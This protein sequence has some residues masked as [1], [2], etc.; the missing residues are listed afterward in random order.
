MAYKLLITVLLLAF[1]SWTTACPRIFTR[2]EWGARAANTAALATNPPTHVV[3]HHSATAGCTT[4]AA[5]MQLVRSFQNFHMDTNGWADI[6]YNFLI[7]GNGEIYQGRGWGRTGAHAPGFNN[8]SLGIA[9]IGTFTS[10]LPPAAAINA[11]H[12]LINCST[13]NGNL[14]TDYWLLG[15]RQA[16]ATACPGNALFNAIQGWPRFTNNP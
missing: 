5:C 15:H 7:G 3:V 8:R 14:R 6:G 12:A 13:G 9:F 10:G 1:V 16:S 2:A 4:Q 11:F